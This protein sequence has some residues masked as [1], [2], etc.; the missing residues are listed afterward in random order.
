M[1]MLTP[2]VFLLVALC[3]AGQWS[4][5]VPDAAHASP[6]ETRLFLEK[7][8]KG[9][10]TATGCSVCPEEMSPSAETW[11]VR[12]VTYGHFLAPTSEDALV[13]GFGCEPHVNLMSGSYLFTK[14]GPSWR[15]VWYNAGELADDCKKLTG[16]DGRDR[17]VCEGSDMHQGV[18][19]WFLYWIDPGRD[20]RKE[21]NGPLELFFGVN[22]TLGSCVYLPGGA[23]ATGKI[24]SVSFVP[25]PA[26]SVRILVTARVGKAEVP[27]KAMESCH[28]GPQNRLAITTVQRNYDFVFD[29]RGV[30]PRRGNPP[31]DNGRAIA[32]TTSYRVAK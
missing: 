21:E 6:A 19:D 10:E 18:A 9:H 14:A 22:D 5:I 8:C 32:P 13:G 4:S 30:V 17:L 1:R 28:P 27:D 26:P 20:P 7:I 11:E 23:I 24:E 2:A 16:S 31:T 25:S 12:S 15:K 3:H 29:G